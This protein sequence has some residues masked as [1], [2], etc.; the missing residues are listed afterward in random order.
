M[1]RLPWPMGASMADSMQAR[2][3]PYV[4]RRRTA[5]AARFVALRS[6][7]PRTV[8]PVRV[9][10]CQLAAL[11]GAGR[12]SSAPRRPNASLQGIPALTGVSR[13]LPSVCAS[14]PPFCPAMGQ[15][16]QATRGWMLPA[17]PGTR[18]S[19]PA[20]VTQRQTGAPTS[21]RT[22]LPTPAPKVRERP[23]ALAPQT[24][25]APPG[26]GVSFSS[27]TARRRASAGRLGRSGLCATSLSRTADATG[28]RSGD[29]AANRTP[30]AQRSA[31]TVARSASATRAPSR[32]RTARG[33]ESTACARAAVHSA[34]ASAAPASPPHAPQ[35]TS[36]PQPLGAVPHV[37]S[38]Q[39]GPVEVPMQL[40]PPGEEHST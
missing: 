17:R 23:A 27:A 12:P 14:I 34:I 18:R 1:H 30:S 33:V 6:R 15:T 32:P 5:R 38:A 11:G 36:P 29:S 19:T 4:R 10:H 2:T 26:I 24:P 37:W 35:S 28:R 39:N 16:S 8:R 25:I 20:P 40:P 22:P 3:R 9:Q 21:R 13:G 31:R 7:G